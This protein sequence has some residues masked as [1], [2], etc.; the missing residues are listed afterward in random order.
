M[1]G[2]LEITLKVSDCLMSHQ[3]FQR[4]NIDPVLEHC[5]LE[6]QVKVKRIKSF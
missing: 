5:K 3:F 4:E 6:G 2:L 1:M